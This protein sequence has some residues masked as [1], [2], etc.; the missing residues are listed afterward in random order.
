MG[1]NTIW[2]KTLDLNL[3]FTQRAEQLEHI[4]GER[5]NAKKLIN[6]QYPFNHIEATGRTYTDK[7]KMQQF[8]KDG[9]IDRYSGQKLV[10]ADKALLEDSYIKKWYRLS[11]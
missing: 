2:V 11:C 7:Q 10:N 4:L 6:E 1:G 5:D 3:P 8:K 9:F